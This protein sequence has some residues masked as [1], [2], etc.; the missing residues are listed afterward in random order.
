MDLKPLQ[1]DSKK[2]KESLNLMVLIK[3]HGKKEKEIR[4]PFH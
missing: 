4:L 2:G 1:Y 3:L